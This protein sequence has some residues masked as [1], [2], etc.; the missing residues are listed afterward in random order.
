MKLDNIKPCQKS[1][2]LVYQKLIWAQ[3]SKGQ[4][5]PCSIRLLLDYLLSSLSVKHI[6]YLHKAYVCLQFCLIHFLSRGPLAPRG[7]LFI[8]YFFSASSSVTRK[9][10]TNNLIILAFLIIFII[11]SLLFLSSPLL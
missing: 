3:G 7:L 4:I 8:Y 5:L 6:H 9:V 2:L 10:I 1:L 11:T